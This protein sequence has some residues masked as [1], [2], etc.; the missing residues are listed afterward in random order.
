MRCNCGWVLGLS[1]AG[2][3]KGIRFPDQKNVSISF[4]KMRYN[5]RFQGFIVIGW[6]TNF[7]SGFNWATWLNS[8][9]THVTRLNSIGRS[10]FSSV[11][12]PN[13]NDRLG[14]HICTTLCRLGDHNRLV[15]QT[16]YVGWVTT[17]G[18]RATFDRVGWLRTHSWATYDNFFSRDFFLS[19]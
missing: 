17:I 2:R 1:I 13:L 11:G 15:G 18:S 14:D 19:K 6:A 12:W 16:Q 8:W 3:L 10:H 5:D 9:A 4:E 7:L